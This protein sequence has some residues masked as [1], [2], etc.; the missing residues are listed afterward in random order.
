[1]ARQKINRPR[2]TGCSCWTLLS[3]QLSW[4]LVFAPQWNFL[5]PRV[6]LWYLRTFRHNF[7]TSYNSSIWLGVFSTGRLSIN[8]ELYPPSTKACFQLDSDAP[9]F[10]TVVLCPWPHAPSTALLSHPLFYLVRFWDRRLN[11][12]AVLYNLARGG[13]RR[14]GKYR[15]VERKKYM[16]WYRVRRSPR[17]AGNIGRGV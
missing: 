1:M 10:G 13:V 5:Y 2:L 14:E 17:C 7:L 9:L 4:N 3:D 11:R 15:G 8:T 6:P 12:V 16:S